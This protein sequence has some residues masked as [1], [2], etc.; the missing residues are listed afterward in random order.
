MRRSAGFF[1]LLTIL[2][3]LSAW[4][5][6]TGPAKS[7]GGTGKERR[8][9]KVLSPSQN[10]LWIDP[11]D[12]ASYDFTYGIGGS[13]SQPQPPFEFVNEDFSGTSKKINVTD[14]QGTK[15][16]LK[17]GHEPRPSVF[18]TRLL[19][20][21]G[22]FV[23][24]EYFVPKGRVNDVHGL[25][26]AAVKVSKDGSFI[27]ARFQLRSDSRKYLEGQHWTWTKNPFVGTPQL[28]GLK[29]MLLLV[30]NWDTKEPNLS[31]FEDNSTGVH[32]YLYMDD[33]W[34]ASLGK[35]GNRFTWS[36]W[37]CKGFAEQTRN[38]VKRDVNGSLQWG[39]VGKNQEEVTSVSVQDVQWLL[40]YLGRVTD[41]QIRTG[42][43]TSG[44]TPKEVECF[45]RSLRDRIEQLQ[46]V[47]GALSN[48]QQ[49][50]DLSTPS[51]EVAQMADSIFQS[52]RGAVRR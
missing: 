10:L 36:K 41:E 43:A 37:D 5:F 45:A 32:R 30:S 34:G 15:W 33:D 14:A 16:N 48:A 38:F 51:L 2:A 8:T 9:S 47:S 49:L 21:L 23:E 26:R 18:C 13:E 27:D 25:K 24:T 31:I 42:L 12:V 39:F 4:Q 35:W 44:A 19:W 46:Q 22:Y 6:H 40:Q 7:T 29:I 20:A 3:L 1:S 11:G 52:M 28:Q 50:H 17:W